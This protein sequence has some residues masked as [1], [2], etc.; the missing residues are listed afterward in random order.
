MDKKKGIQELSAIIKGLIEKQDGRFMGDIEEKERTTWYLDTN[1]Y[2]LYCD[3]NF[4]LRIRKENNSEEYDVTLKCRHPDRYVSASYNLASSVES[5]DIK[6]EEDIVIPFISKFSLSASLK[7]K[8]IPR[9]STIQDVVTVFPGLDLGIDT[10]EMLSKVNNFEVIEISSK[11]G[12]IKFSGDDTE[13]EPEL[14]LWYSS[15]KDDKPLIVEFTFKCKAAK[16]DKAE[17]MLLEEYS[18]SLVLD[19]DSFYQSLQKDK[20]VDKQTTKTKTKTKTDF[21][22]QNSCKP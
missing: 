6:F 3:N 5:I 17:K 1:A 14:N 4:L 12:K 20:I 15:T 16:Q 9:F 11:I 10:G 18:H 2:K 7:G 13:I 8:Q 22:Y 21:V 19:A